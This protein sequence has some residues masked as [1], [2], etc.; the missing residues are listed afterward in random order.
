MDL[1]QTDKRWRGIARPDI[2]FVWLASLFGLIWLVIFPP[3]QGPDEYEHYYRA[4][5]TALGH[6][7]CVIGEGGVAGGYLPK[8][9]M[10]LDQSMRQFLEFRPDI[11][12]QP[13]IV[14]DALSIPLQP[15]ERLFVR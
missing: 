7:R 12:A 1:T 14:F 13:H 4:N 8:G 10:E 5:W 15:E 3:F 11:K 9:V 2:C 6:M